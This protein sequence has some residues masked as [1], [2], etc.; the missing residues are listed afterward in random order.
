MT[1][2]EH[3]KSLLTSAETYTCPDYRWM[4][5]A[6]WYENDSLTIDELVQFF[7][8]NWDEMVVWA[9]EK[10]IKLNGDWNELMGVLE[11][12]EV[13]LWAEGIN[14]GFDEEEEED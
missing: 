11:A 4:D 5:I 10:H 9:N 8:M 13:T 12:I 6:D 3:I 7:S 1:M 2:S 14:A